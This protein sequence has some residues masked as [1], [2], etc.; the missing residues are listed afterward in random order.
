MYWHM[1]FELSKGIRDSLPGSKNYPVSTLMDQSA[2]TVV[3]R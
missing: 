1:D 2:G 3:Q